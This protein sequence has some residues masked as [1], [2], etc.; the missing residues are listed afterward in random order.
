[1]FIVQCGSQAE[2]QCVNDMVE[3]IARSGSPV[4]S[5]QIGEAELTLEERREELLHQYRTRP[6][7]FLERY[8]VCVHSH[9]SVC[10][11]VFAHT[12]ECTCAYKQLKGALT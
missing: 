3:A 1:M 5:Q 11:C 9:S 4:K 8:H 7:V 10:V 12:F 6:L 2:S